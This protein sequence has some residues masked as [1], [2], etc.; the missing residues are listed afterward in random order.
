[1]KHPVPSR[2]KA[3]HDATVTG[4]KYR[5]TVLSEALLRYEWA[6]DGKFEDRASTFAINRNWPVPEY[7]VNDN[8]EEGLEIVT[9][10]FHLSYDKKRLDPAGLVVDVKGKLTLWGA[11]WRF[12]DYGRTL[13]GTARTL[14]EVDGRC[15]MGVGVC[16]RMG[17][18]CIDDSKSM[19]F[20]GSGWVAGRRPGDREDGYLFAFGHDYKGA[21]KAYYKLSGSQPLLPRWALGNWWSRYH[22]YSD[23]EYLGL[24]DQF[25]SEGIPLSVGVLDMD[26]HLVRDKR[27]TH[28]G[29]TGYTWNDKL[30]P[31]PPAFG[32]EMHKRDLKITLN[33]HPHSG[34]HAFED[35]YE[36][37][38]K[39]IGHDT[40]HKSPIL[41]DPTNQKFFKG[42]FEIVHRNVEKAV[43]DF[44]WIDWQQGEH[45]RIPGVDPLWMLNHYQM[46]D[47]TRDGQRNIIFS[48]FAGPGSQRYP[49]GFSGDTVVSWASLHF[50]PEFTATASNIGYGWWSHDIGGHMGGGRDDQLVTRWVQYGVFSPL[51]RL[52]STHR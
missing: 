13:G 36:E 12:G 20:D 45:S 48:R 46:E 15:D 42:F 22:A 1:M 18:A 11:Q 28:S 14:D 21:I 8:G 49:V 7:H 50:Q 32:K 27:V 41:F 34:I 25:R 29:W 2:P 39:A 9:D 16:S 4:P 33:D 40:S 24:M 31:D 35:S 47:S 51:M 52:H 37:L 3:N 5:F 43:C 19:L 17:F 30:F 38:A 10:C 44:W 6:E 26:W 23:K